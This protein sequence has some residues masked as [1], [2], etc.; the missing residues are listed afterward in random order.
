MRENSVQQNNE[1]NQAKKSS[2]LTR[3]HLESMVKLLVVG[4]DIVLQT[5][6]L[7]DSTL[8]LYYDCRAG[9]VSGHQ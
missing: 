6:P 2:F 1:E 3:D 9:I 7:A 5:Q 8:G 4:T